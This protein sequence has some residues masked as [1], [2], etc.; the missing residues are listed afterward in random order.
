MPDVIKNPQSSRVHI[1]PATHHAREQIL[2]I[3]QESFS[4]PWTRKMFDAE[5][6]GNPFSHLY[7]ARSVH[8]SSAGIERGEVVG[9]ICFWVVF[10]ELRFMNLA[11]ER[12]ARRRGIAREL[13][14]HA[15]ALGRERGAAR[16]VLEV[17][18]S[19]E[20]ARCLYEQAGFHH[21]AARA[22]YYT[23]PIE[24]AILMGRDIG[25]GKA[26]AQAEVQDS[27]RLRTQPQ[28]EP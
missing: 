20:A 16:A 14:R 28:P 19:N 27:E 26:E 23:N 7:V 21:L 11:V 5:L 8:E 1:E 17:R 2:R 6:D 25:D 3:E 4:A 18:A 22:E 13:V 9:Y 10:D 12:A 15:L 24:D